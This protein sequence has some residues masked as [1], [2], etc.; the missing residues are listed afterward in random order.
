MS[1]D[2]TTKNNKIIDKDI[3]LTDSS[4]FSDKV[5]LKYD[6]S[7][8]KTENDIKLISSIYKDKI[9]Q[10]SS[11]LFLNKYEDYAIY[12]DIN[13]VLCFKDNYLDFNLYCF[14]CGIILTRDEDT[15]CYECNN[16]VSYERH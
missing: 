1:E 16:D 13:D 10:R 7:L 2:D 14:R 3:D 5:F 4:L 12:K 8:I 9:Q 11:K 6:I 15:L